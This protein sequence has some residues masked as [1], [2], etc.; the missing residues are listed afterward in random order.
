MQDYLCSNFFLLQSLSP[1]NI[2][3][4]QPKNNNNNNKKKIQQCEDVT[5]AQAQVFNVE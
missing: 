2:R 4:M 5:Y 1:R 3:C